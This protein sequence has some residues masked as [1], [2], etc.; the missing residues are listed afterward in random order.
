MVE[1]V[2]E[3]GSEVQLEPLGQREILRGRQVE[4]HQPR[5]VVLVATFG[6]NLT[7][8]NGGEVAGVER[9]T[10]ALVMLNEPTRTCVWTIGKL[11]E[12]AVIRTT[13]I[14][15]EGKPRLDLGNA[16]HRPAFKRLTRDDVL[17]RQEHLSRTERQ[18]NRVV[19]H[20]AVTHVERRVAIL[21][22]E[23]VAVR[24]ITEISRGPEE[25]RAVVQRVTP[26]VRAL[27]GNTMRAMIL[28][29]RH[30]AAVVGVDRCTAIGVGKTTIVVVG[31]YLFVRARS[32][33]LG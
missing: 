1:E 28:H 31:E 24:R 2:E 27:G 3:I 23:V 33:A 12:T 19:A 16:R 32:T 9:P 22:L 26:G 5:T 17:R 13:Q 8:R 21:R 18:W 11:V 14:D 7:C 29:H 25:G 15:R 6:A 4:V 30:C 20:K 10:G